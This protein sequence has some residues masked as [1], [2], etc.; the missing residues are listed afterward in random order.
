MVKIISNVLNITRTA[1]PN[2][3]YFLKSNLKKE[4]FCIK[5]LTVFMNYCRVF[6]TKSTFGYNLQFRTKLNFVTYK[7]L[8]SCILNK[9]FPALVPVIGSKPGN[10]PKTRH[11]Q[12][13]SISFKIGICSKR[14]SSFIKNGFSNRIIIYKVGIFCFIV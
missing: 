14:K 13:C 12:K 8:I 2:L 6:V 1:I 4:F 3:N 10:V 11:E 5:T 7:I 9:Q